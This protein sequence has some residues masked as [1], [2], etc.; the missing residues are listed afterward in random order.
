M[1]KIVNNVIIGVIVIILVLINFSSIVYADMGPKP[2]IT[3]KL[4]NMNTDNYL[5]DLLVYDETGENYT[6]EMDY[7]GE[8]LTE[9]QIKTL[10]DINY[11]GWI[12][13]S[14]R[15]NEYLLFAECAGTSEREHTFSYFG[16]PDTYKVIVINNDTGEIK[17]SDVINRE[18]FKSYV[19]LDVNLMGAKQRIS[20]VGIVGTLILTI[21]VEL[22]IALLMRIR[23]NIKLILITNFVTNI[24]LQLFFLL[25]SI[26]F[27]I[28]EFVII[29]MLVILVEFLIYKKYMKG[30]L[31]NKILLYTFVSNTITAM[32]TFLI[33]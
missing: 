33:K 27:K 4:E 7:N 8:G 12:S 29:E 16:T 10:Y 31:Q 2:S 24:I 17:I 15:W 9:S 18:E 6:S 26:N 20:F 30:Q 5:I 13:E 32:L 28:V 3:I 25:F 22:V 11:D 21:I 1:K 19:T 14:T 23:N